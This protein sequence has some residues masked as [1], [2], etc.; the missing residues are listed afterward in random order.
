MLVYGSQ[1]MQAQ[2]EHKNAQKLDVNQKQKQKRL[3]TLNLTFALERK[4]EH[5]Y[6][7]FWKPAYAQYLDHMKLNYTN[8]SGLF[9][10]DEEFARG[11]LS[12]S[13]YD[14]R[15]RSNSLDN[16]SI[17]KFTT[18][19][20]FNKANLDEESGEQ[21][22]LDLDD[23]AMLI[24]EQQSTLDKLLI[25]GKQQNGKSFSLDHSYFSF[26]IIL[27]IS[28]VD[29]DGNQQQIPQIQRMISKLGWLS[30]KALEKVHEQ[31]KNVQQITQHLQVAQMQHV[32]DQQQDAQVQ[33]GK[34]II[35]QESPRI[36]L[37]DENS[38]TE[39]AQKT[40]ATE[41]KNTEPQE[42]LM[43]QINEIIGDTAKT[44]DV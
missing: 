1:T 2:E 5:Q 21:T 25:M 17:E 28:V 32:I 38:D 37:G 19:T 6:K 26:L 24:N 31:H 43:A 9:R 8:S 33:N 18:S 41:N 39:D 20:S 14:T 27:F 16:L 34:G 13:Q 35:A 10:L 7:A 3:A 44:E 12:L 4:L 40:E 42:R 36:F 11:N 22:R 15:S 23:L 29:D 30:K